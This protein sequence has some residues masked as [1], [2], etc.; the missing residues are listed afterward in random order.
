MVAI[1][2]LLAAIS[3][4]D[5]YIVALL[6]APIMEELDLRPTDIGVLIGIG[7]GLLYAVSS[8]PL[9]HLIDRHNRRW[10]IAIGVTIWSIATVASAFSETFSLLLVTR[11]GVAIG[12]AVLVP[13][14]VSLIGDLFA[15]HR[16]A[17]P[18]GAFM[19]ISTLMG[20]ASFLIGGWIL[21][22]SEGLDTFLAPWRM[23]LL[24]VGVAGLI[25]VPVWLI[26]SREPQRSA[27]E[28]EPSSASLRQT[29]DY[30]AAR[31]D[32]FMP[33]YA[34]FAISAIVT[35]GFISWGTTMLVQSHGLEVPVAGERFGIAGMIG[36]IAS[37]ILWPWIGG[38][39]IAS[40]R[41]DIAVAII[42]AALFLGNVAVVLLSVMAGLS[43]TLVL[44]MFAVF[45]QGAAA[46]LAVLSLQ[47]VAPA[48]M[49]A[50]LTSLYMLAGN[51][52]CLIFGPMIVAQLAETVYS[53]PDAIRYSLVLTAAV[54]GIG[55]A[56]MFGLAAINLCRSKIN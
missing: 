38:R 30:I 40:R 34:G 21:G 36:G 25:V 17:L 32:F 10:I 28:A 19:A 56:L 13:A 1:L 4:L 22:W 37:A 20:S 47:A 49:R 29:L 39:A 41:T 48:P 6:A 45:G 53:G 3:Y 31:W 42:G 7:F 54:C 50:R 33:F 8:V 27:F 43:F 5:R 44:I 2:C 35:Y 11:A 46:G 51:F 55:T 52:A 23:T 9:A 12:E 15:P 16:R 26:A 18:I 24:V 14:T